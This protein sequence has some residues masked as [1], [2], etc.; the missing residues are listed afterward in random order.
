[1]KIEGQVL[2]SHAHRHLASQDQVLSSSMAIQ[3]E[4]AEA[5]L[6][7]LMCLQGV[8]A[9]T[10]VNQVACCASFHSLDTPQD[11]GDHV[12]LPL[13]QPSHVVRP[14]LW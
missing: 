3:G 12:L 11:R 4:Q 10:L 7:R 6:I 2:E 13:D 8:T 5:E 9:V 1:M 14:V